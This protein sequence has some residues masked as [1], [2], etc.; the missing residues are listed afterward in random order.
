MSDKIRETGRS[1]LVLG[2]QFIQA[3]RHGLMIMAA[4]P[5]NDVRVLFANAGVESIT[6]YP[7]AEIEGRCPRFLLAQG[8]DPAEVEGLCAAIA[9][10]R[11]VSVL[12]RSTRKD[13][14]TFWAAIDVDPVRDA[15]RVV[16][17]IATIQDVSERAL[18][19]A[20]LAQ[21]SQL[22]TVG[23]L[24]GA[25]AHDFNNILA[26]VRS[27]AGLL[28][29]AVPE[30]SDEHQYA[31]RIV[32]ACR[33]AADMV[34]QLLAFVRAH[35]AARERVH[36]DDI[37]NEVAALLQTRLDHA[38]TLSVGPLKAKS[39]VLANGSQLTQVLLNLAI[40]ACDAMA[41]AGGELRISTQDTLIDNND[42]L[43]FDAG[44]HGDESGYIYASGQLMAGAP[45]VRV[46]VAD[47]GSGIPKAIAESIFEPFF[48]TKDKRRGSGLG[49]AIVR[50]I[51]AT[52]GGVLTVQSRPGAGST[53]D[54]YLPAETVLFPQPAVETL[55]EI[56]DKGGAAGC[57]RL[58]LVDDDV[59]VA[60]AFSISLEH[61]GYAVTRAYH[62]ARALALLKANPAAFD[63]LVSD[64][65]MPDM[66]GLTLIHEAKKLNPRLKAVLCSGSGNAEEDR[67][68]TTEA[69]G[70]FGKPGSPL[71]LARIVRA[72]LDGQ[73][74]GKDR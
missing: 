9:A 18:A 58:L 16:H 6:G 73:V 27:F 46:S 25:I 42:A 3:A 10:G 72:V 52:Y 54:F 29:D 38:T 5:D 65:N 40:N 53:F 30:T 69:E 22:E 33:R 20:R 36:I 49:L 71:T 11:P 45:Y 60:D 68:Q 66:T 26:S 67:V 63:L 61:L 44:L 14:E 32:A 17:C 41:S 57:E 48:S 8:D 1:R 4:G 12:I 50:S 59:D 56:N 64:N 34:R 7:A 62:P 37:V 2:A 23:R 70:F 28:A 74:T 35:D 31:T 39:T 55:A 13:G 24:T 15:G 43:P 19:H 51:V 47:M 21:L